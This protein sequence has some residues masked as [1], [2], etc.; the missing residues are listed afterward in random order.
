MPPPAPPPSNSSK[1]ASSPRPAPDNLPPAPGSSGGPK[2]HGGS[3]GFGP[4]RPSPHARCA[5]TAA[6]LEGGMLLFG[7]RRC[8]PLSRRVAASV[9]QG[10]SLRH[11]GLQP[12]PPTV[13]GRCHT[14]RAT[15][16]GRLSRTRGSWTTAPRGGSPLRPTWPTWPTTADPWAARQPR[17]T[18]ARGGCWRRSMASRCCSTLT[19]GPGFD[20]IPNPSPNP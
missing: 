1:A 16:R 12:P 19:P 5:H 18:A 8:Q 10:G 13:A 14:R 17:S 2:A 15:T 9:T 3:T 6:A 11:T 20:P 4:L 7:G